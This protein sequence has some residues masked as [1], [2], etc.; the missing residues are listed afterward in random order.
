MWGGETSSFSNTL[1][2]TFVTECCYQWLNKI[3]PNCGS[4]AVW[5]SA[6]TNWVTAVLVTAATSKTNCSGLDFKHPVLFCIQ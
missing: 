5:P 4:L 3:W 1:P 6:W 2:V